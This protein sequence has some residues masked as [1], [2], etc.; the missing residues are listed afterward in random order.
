MIDRESGSM[1]R[2]SWLALAVTLAAGCSSAKARA[3]AKAR[4]PKGPATMAGLLVDGYIADLKAAAKE[5]RIQAARELAGMGAEAKKALPAL[6]AMAA[7]KDAAVS[8][9]AERAIA[10][11]RR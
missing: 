7:D 2:R 10:A 6:E 8:E 9:A 5:K 1:R 11:I 3:K 4:K